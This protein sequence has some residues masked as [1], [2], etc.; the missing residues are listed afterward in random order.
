MSHAFLWK[1]EV[2]DEINGSPTSTLLAAHDW[3][4]DDTPTTFRSY[5]DIRIPAHHVALTQALTATH[6]LAVEHGKWHGIDRERRLCR[7]C[8]D[9]VEDVPHVLF[10]CPCQPAESIR[11]P[12][13]SSV[14]SRYPA[15]TPPPPSCRNR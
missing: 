4:C 12:F 15:W 13:L 10:V 6:R 14:W 8:Y 7:M 5:L 9:E 1:T 3:E 11:R 2:V